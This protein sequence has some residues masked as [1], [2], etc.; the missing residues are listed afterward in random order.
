MLKAL[1]LT[2]IANAHGANGPITCDFPSFETGETPIRVV[3]E[4]KPSLKDQPGLFRVQ[5]DLNGKVSVT[6]SAQPILATED[7]DIMIR[8][9]SE[10]QAMYTI[11]FRED[12]RAA[13]NMEMLR[14]SDSKILTATRIGACRDFEAH[15]DRWLPL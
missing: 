12:G 3:L 8:G 1:L 4:P 14:E 7:R 6:A 15:L 11:G 13:L 9:L 5:M 2:I 10:K